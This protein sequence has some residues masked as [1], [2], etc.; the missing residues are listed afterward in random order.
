MSQVKLTADSG[1]GS[2]A[3]KAPATT[4][5]NAAIEITVPDVATGSSI[6]TKASG[7]D[8]TIDNGNLVVGT[9][10]KGI[11]FSATSGTGESELLADY[12]EGTFN[13]TMAHSVTLHSSHDT[14]NYVKV[15]T[16]VHV[17]G[18]CRINDGQS[19]AG[20]SITNMPFATRAS[21]DASG[22]GIGSVSLYDQSMPSGYTQA[23]C[24]INPNSSTLSVQ[25]MKQTG[26][27]LEGIDCDDNGYVGVNITYRSA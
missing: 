27:I 9:S 25:C 24:A 12:E 5:S 4:T 8:V 1:G 2:V 11:D 23:I 10:G 7:G 21:A 17:T 14:L 16:L 22:N 13:P 15:G 18:I 19:G 3:L 6:V 26:N 20:F